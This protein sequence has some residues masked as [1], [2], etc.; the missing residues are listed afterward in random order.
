MPEFVTKPL[1]AVKIEEGA[2]RIEDNGVR[3]FLFIGTEKALL[4]DTGFGNAGSVRALVRSLTD[5][6]IYL[7]NTHADDDHTGKNAEFETTHIHPA[8]MP[9]F[10][11]AKRGPAAEPIWEGDVIDVGGWRFEVVLIP[12][13]TPGSIA[14]LNREKRFISIGDTV[15]TTP[16]FIFS[17]IRSIYAYMASLDKLQRMSG[18]FDTIYSMHGDYSVPKEQIGKLRVAAEKLVAG[19]LEPMEPPFPMPAKMYAHEGAM[20][21]Y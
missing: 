2:F 5:K 6:P 16:V 10:Y 12:G 1:E 3:M 14:L 18:D 4:V 17:E 15:S 8:E 13:H 19:E 7:V 9:Y 11:S 21:F 20:F